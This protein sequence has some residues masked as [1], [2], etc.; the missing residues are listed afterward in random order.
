MP[1][2]HVLHPRIGVTLP[3][4][5]TRAD[6]EDQI[7]A[8]IVDTVTRAGGEVDLLQLG[9]A[10]RPEWAAFGPID[11]VTNTRLQDRP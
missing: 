10:A 4:G 6:I 1:P 5:T 2:R 11:R 7:A 9:P 3:D 8:A